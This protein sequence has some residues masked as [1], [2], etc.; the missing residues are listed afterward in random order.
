[1]LEF[2]VAFM[3]YSFWISIFLNFVV[4]FGLRIMYVFRNNLDTNA[5]LKVLF[6]PFS[7]GY[8]SHNK[9]KSVFSRLYTFIIII[10]F[11][12]MLIGGVMVFY[13]RFF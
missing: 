11:L 8:L 9:T 5:I 2:L 13:T 3:L 1:M 4:L 6:L 7:F 12:L 10:T